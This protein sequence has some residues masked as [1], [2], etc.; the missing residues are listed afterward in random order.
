MQLRV[1]HSLRSQGHHVFADDFDE[2]SSLFQNVIK[3]R[4]WN[5]L[6]GGVY[7][8]LVPGEDRYQDIHISPG[9]FRGYRMDSGPYIAASKEKISEGLLAIEGPDLTLDDFTLCPSTSSGLLAIM[10]MLRETGVRNIVLELPAYFAIVEQANALGLNVH[11]HTTP[12]DNGY[13]LEPEDVQKVTAAFPGTPIA[14]FVTQP[15]YGLGFNRT[16]DEFAVFCKAMR[17]EDFL[18]IDEAADQSTPS[19]TA[20]L[21]NA[22]DRPSVIRVRG[23][24]KGLG[25]NGARVAC[26]FHPRRLRAKFAEIVDYTGAA[27][28]TASLAMAI[29]VVADQT[30]YAQYLQF[31]QNFV[32]AQFH[33]LEKLLVGS[34]IRLSPI[35]S[36]YIATAAVDTNRPASEFA[37]WRE[38]FLNVC[39][40]EKLPIVL[41]SSMYFPYDFTKEFVRINYF[42]P[43]PLLEKSVNILRR[44]VKEVT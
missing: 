16:G 9:Q 7:D 42:T 40:R 1:F 21:Q 13:R 3:E 31:A 17:P 34:P 24:M 33:T 4:S 39:L 5:G 28:D 14:L 30:Q 19:P 44:I 8:T 10:L 37:Q 20:S 35:E 18:I 32:R 29:Q 38:K 26:I 22:I 27:L 11:L 2:V 43:Q 15:R 23:L 41:G 12:E 6:P 25:L 36:G